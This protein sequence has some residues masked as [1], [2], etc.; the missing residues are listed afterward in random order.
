MCRTGVTLPRCAVCNLVGELTDMLE[1]NAD[2][3][4]HRG[5]CWEAW[6]QASE[7]QRIEWAVRALRQS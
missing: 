3:Y 6:I 2:V 1:P 4:V 7:S 5:A